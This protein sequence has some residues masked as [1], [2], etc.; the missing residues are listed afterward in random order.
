MRLKITGA[1]LAVRI[2]VQGRKGRSRETNR[3]KEK[4]AK[5]IVV[6]VD[7]ENEEEE[8][9]KANCTYLRHSTRAHNL[10]LCLLVLRNAGERRLHFCR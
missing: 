6:V 8:E 7:E 9:R 5:E 1:D 10:C 3:T 2:R 4:P